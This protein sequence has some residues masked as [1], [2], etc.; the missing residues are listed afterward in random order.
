MTLDKKNRN[1]IVNSGIISKEQNKLYGKL[2]E[3]R[4]TGDYSDVIVVK[5]KNVKPLLEPAENFIKTIEQ[6]I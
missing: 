1:D 3:L 5:E 6:L 2:L 4:Q